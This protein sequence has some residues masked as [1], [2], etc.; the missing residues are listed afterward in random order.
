MLTQKG[1]NQELISFK[2]LVRFV[3]SVIPTLLLFVL[4]LPVQWSMF[5]YSQLTVNRDQEQVVSE[6]FGGEK[7]DL[8]DLSFDW[9]CMSQNHRGV[10]LTNC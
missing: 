7:K 2:P 6:R 8:A 5:Q 1:E 3:R 4:S 9:P 10:S